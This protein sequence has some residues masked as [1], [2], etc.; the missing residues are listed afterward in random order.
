MNLGSVLAVAVAAACISGAQASAAVEI[1]DLW[2]AGGPPGFR[3]DEPESLD[4]QTGDDQR[5]DRFI[6]GVSIPTLAIH[7]PAERRA[8]GA[9]VLVLPGGGFRHVVVDKEGHDVARWLNT[10]GVT[11]AVLKY[12]TYGPKKKLSSAVLEAGLADARRAMRH[13]RSRAGELGIDPERVGVMGFSA[14][15]DFAIRLAAAAEVDY[16]PSFVTLVYPGVPFG[17]QL[18]FRGTTAPFFIVHASD[19]PKAPLLLSTRLAQ[20]LA[21][22]GVPFEL[23]AFQQ[24]DHGFALGLNGGGVRW[25]PTLFEEWLRDQGLLDRRVARVVESKPAGRVQWP[26]RTFW[27]A[28]AGAAFTAGVGATLVLWLLI[29]GVFAVARRRKPR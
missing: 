27:F 18:D 14:G 1:I 22:A 24:G 2:P 9:A 13:L 4:D 3:N 20:E 23:H 8:T 11:A 25:W 21:S 6:G 29:N 28:G 12:R 10:I 15:G 26:V 19:D 16:R 17:A 7:S 5:R